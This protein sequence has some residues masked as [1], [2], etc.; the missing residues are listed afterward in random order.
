MNRLSPGNEGPP[1]AKP[2]E[3]VDTG[4]P[5]HSAAEEVSDS[6]RRCLADYHVDPR[7]PTDPNV[8]TQG[9]LRVAKEPLSEVIVQAREEI[10]RLYAI[11]RQQRYVV[12]LCN[13]DG[14]AIHHRGDETWA[15]EFKHWGIWL[16]GVWSEQIEGTNGI[17]TAITEQRPVLVQ[18]GQHFRARHANLTCAGAP[19]FDADNKLTAVLDAS[20]I[21]LGRSVRTPGLVLA[22]VNASVRA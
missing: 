20:R 13:E 19:I 15:E 12:L 9:E 4:A 1:R 3:P 14:V 18:C 17:G 11:V 7:N 5:L 8:I 22:A 16:G 10:D 6:W 2:L 21:D